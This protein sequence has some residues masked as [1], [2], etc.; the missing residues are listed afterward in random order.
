MYEAV[1]A[2]LRMCIVVG[3]K[4]VSLKTDSQLVKG[5]LKGEFEVK[6]PNMQ[7]YVENGKEMIAQ[8]DHF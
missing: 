5:Q 7:N 3:A 4:S 1:I 2:G 8:L 6:E